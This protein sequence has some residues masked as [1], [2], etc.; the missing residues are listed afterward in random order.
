[1]LHY[2]AVER[3][4]RLL[5]TMAKLAMNFREVQG[6]FPVSTFSWAFSSL[7]VAL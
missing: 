2:S 5:F 4:S 7:F 3:R 1:M 6:R